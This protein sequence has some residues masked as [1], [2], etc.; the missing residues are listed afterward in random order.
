M[1]ND[2][3]VATIKRDLKNMGI[4]CVVD[5]VLYLIMIVNTFFC[6]YHLRICIFFAHKIS[7]L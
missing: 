6:Q 1:R 7:F 4:V 3:P 5:L 2:V